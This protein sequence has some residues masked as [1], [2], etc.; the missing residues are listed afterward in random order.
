MSNLLSSDFMY[1]NVASSKS[2]PVHAPLLPVS[3]QSESFWPFLIVN[4]SESVSS[5]SSSPLDDGTKDGGVAGEVYTYTEVGGDK[6]WKRWHPFYDYSD[7]TAWAIADTDA[8]PGETDVF[9]S[10]GDQYLDIEYTY[11]GSD[12]AMRI[13]MDGMDFSDDGANNGVFPI[14]GLDSVHIEYIENAGDVA[15]S[16]AATGA[17][18]DGVDYIGFYAMPTDGTWPDEDWEFDYDADADLGENKVDYYGVYYDSADIWDT[19]LGSGFRAPLTDTGSREEDF[20]T[21]RGTVI[22]TVTDSKIQFTVPKH[23]RDVLWSFNTAEAAESAD[24]T[25]WTGGEGD[26][27]VVGGVT[28]T[29]D[30]IDETLSTCGV[31]AGGSATCTYKDGSAVA[32][33]NGQPS[34]TVKEANPTAV[35]PSSLVILDKDAGSTASVISVGGEVV[36]TVTAQLLAGVEHNYDTGPVVQEVG[37]SIVVAG[38]EAPDTLQAA[39]D[40]IN[41]LTES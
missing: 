8:N 7:A 31:S 5:A 24:T 6:C 35:N 18:S 15:D 2:S 14:T 28:V 30:S 21:D 4:S 38:K 11:G 23:V 12:S 19:S 27:T 22:D 39:M 10:D 32:T 29:V 40:F 25:T 1:N 3:H 26:S 13:D 36:N 9:D 20:I 37:G 34:I 17:T 41:G 16:T 33:I